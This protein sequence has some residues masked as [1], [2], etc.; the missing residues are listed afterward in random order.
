VGVCQ[1]VLHTF[2]GALGDVPHEARKRKSKNDFVLSIKLSTP[3]VCEAIQYALLQ[4]PLETPYGTYISLVTES[5]SDGVHLEPFIC[6]F[7]RKVGGDV[8]FSFTVV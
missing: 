3:V 8:D 6:E 7:M 4:C 1:D 2:L 5:D